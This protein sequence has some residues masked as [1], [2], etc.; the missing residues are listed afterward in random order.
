M[1]S[2]NIKENIKS[3]RTL[4]IVGTIILVVA[5][6]LAWFAVSNGPL[7]ETFK[8]SNFDGTSDCYFMA[9]TKKDVSSF[10][11]A[12][13]SINL[14]LDPTKDNYIGNFRAD[15]KYKGT[16]SAYM[17]VKVACEFDSAGAATLATSKV[18]FVLS[19][20]YDEEAGGNQSAWFDNRNADSCYYFADVVKGNKDSYTTMSLITGIN[21][22]DEDGSFDIE[23]LKDNGINVKIA[24]GVEMVQINRYPQFWSIDNL[25]WES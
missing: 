5:V 18:P 21:Q 22:T 3:K 24:I 17:R 4:V 25:P 14:S 12:D 9:G 7:S 6:T 10:K 1:K 23:D 20:E 19:S 13:G 2:G 15:V 8:L 16:G 11:N